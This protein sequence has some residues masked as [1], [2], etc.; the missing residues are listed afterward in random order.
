MPIEILIELGLGLLISL[1][2]GPYSFGIFQS[3]K[4]SDHIKKTPQTEFDYTKM[5]TKGRIS[6][7]AAVNDYLPQELTS[8]DLSQKNSTLARF[9]CN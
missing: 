1:M 8:L 5:F 4:S 3:V 6:L 9:I 7:A 2:A